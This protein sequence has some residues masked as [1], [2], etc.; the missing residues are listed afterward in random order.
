[1]T[2]TQGLSY[3]I[4]GR[5]NALKNPQDGDRIDVSCGTGS[6]S[7]DLPNGDK[8][9]LPS[10]IHIWADGHWQAAEASRDLEGKV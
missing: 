10:G 5:L 3:I 7:V 8:A 1:M 9:E 2:T 6:I 4:S